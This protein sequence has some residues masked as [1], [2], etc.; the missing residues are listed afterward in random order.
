MPSGPP[1]CL[2]AASARRT[3]AT[4]CSSWRTPTAGSPN[5]LRGK[6]QEP[7]KRLAGGHTVNLQ[8]EV[9]L[10]GWPTPAARD[11]RSE[12]ASEAYQAERIEQTR[13]KPLS[14]MVQLAAWP[15]PR[16]SGAGESE[17]SYANRK[18]TEYEKYPGK[19]IGGLSLDVA[20]QLA[21]WPTPK[22]TA[23]RKSVTAMDRQDYMSAMD[24]EQTA[25]AA[26][27]IMPREIHLLRPEMQR[28]LGFGGE[29]SGPARLAS[30]QMLTGSSAATP[31]GGQLN[32]AHSRWL[33]G[34]PSSWDRAA[35]TKACP[36]PE[37]SEDTATP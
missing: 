30:G 6:G 26:C 10:A 22:V 34:L 29:W 18:R 16:V 14:E 5:S 11:W 31:S 23:C 33:M 21:G 20:A 32:P 37:C 24:L 19:G 36:E 28:R 4:G 9:M 15:T 13:G 12:S 27:G 1:S 7:S 35:P 8:D 17:E 25:E 2:L 3:S